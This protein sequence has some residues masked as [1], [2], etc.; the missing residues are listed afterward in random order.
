MA[1]PPE[2]DS[3]TFI[4]VFSDC[5]KEIVCAIFTSKRTEYVVGNDSTRVYCKI[6]TIIEALARA[7][8][9]V[10]LRSAI[11]GHCPIY[12]LCGVVPLAQ[13]VSHDLLV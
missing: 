1:A 5:N 8:P 3:E 4:Q 2:E 6:V 11:Q 12:T 10:H 13:R 9:A 7:C